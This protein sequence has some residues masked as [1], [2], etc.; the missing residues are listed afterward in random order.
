MNF[1]GASDVETAIRIIP[2]LGVA[3]LLVLI[4]LGGYKGWWVFGWQYR[5]LLNRHEKLRADRDKWQD[6]AMSANNLVELLA[7]LRKGGR[8]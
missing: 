3:A 4:L 7:K 5:E 8:L 1:A 2:D 6:I